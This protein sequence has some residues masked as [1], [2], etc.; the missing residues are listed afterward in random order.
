MDNLFQPVLRGKTVIVGIGNALRGDDGFGP[1]LIERLRG[2]VSAICIDAGN[3]PENY[4]GRIIKEAPDTILLVDVAHLDL[5]PGQ[6]R[7]LEPDDI[8]PSGLT[9]HDMS[10]RMLIAFLQEQTQATILMLAVQPQQV[11]LGESLSACV[12]ETLYT[13]EQQLQEAAHA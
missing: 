11:S 4:V 13:L 3:A 5:E 1:A 9:T 12:T 2:K 8:V 6:Y 7:L 10:S